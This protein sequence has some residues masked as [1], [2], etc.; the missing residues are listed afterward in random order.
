MPKVLET[1]CHHLAQNRHELWAMNKILNGWRFAEH[2]N[3]LQKLH[4]ALTTFDRLPADDKQRYITTAM[5]N[6]K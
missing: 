6:L 2:G 3:D 1:L 5:E 4:A